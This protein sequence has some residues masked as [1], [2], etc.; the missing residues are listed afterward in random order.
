MLIGSPEDDYLSG[1][2]GNDRVAGRNGDDILLGGDDSD[3]LRGERGSD[4]L[5]GH[6]GR[7]VLSGGPGADR[8]I[9]NDLTHSRPGARRDIIADFEQGV[10]RIDLRDIDAR[11]EAGDQAFVFLGMRRFTG[12]GGEL[13]YQIVRGDTIV[14]ADTNG[15]KK[16][17]LQI[18]LIGAFDLTDMDFRR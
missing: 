13:R 4:A 5:K 14:S 11:K 18:K 3:H 17:N 15:D 6:K 10:D 7:D 16:P 2:A 9:F 12:A 1:R 8:F